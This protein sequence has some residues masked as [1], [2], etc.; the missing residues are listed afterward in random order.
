MGFTTDGAVLQ[1]KNVT[2]NLRISTR[3]QINKQFDQLADQQFLLNK[4]INKCFL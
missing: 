3:I 1:H 2:T 4:L